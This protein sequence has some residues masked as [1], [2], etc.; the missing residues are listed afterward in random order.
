[1]DSIKWVMESVG[2]FGLESTP[3]QVN[4]GNCIRLQFSQ[5]DN[6]ARPPL[7]LSKQSS[8]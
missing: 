7:A 1:M 4:G 5:S 3:I 6:S 8:W 2:L